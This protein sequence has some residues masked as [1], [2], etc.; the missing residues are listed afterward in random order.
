[1]TGLNRPAEYSVYVGQE[2]W[3]EI[4]LAAAVFIAMCV[5]SFWAFTPN[6]VAARV[7]G[8][9]RVRV[10]IISRLLHFVIAAACLTLLA[11]AGYRAFAPEC[12]NGG[13][14]YLSEVPAT[15]LAVAIGTGVLNKIYKTIAEW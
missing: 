6:S 12:V 8:H 5:S 3:Q 7:V 4:L 11:V 13:C 15:A 10:P 9:S 2:M 14:G 1:M